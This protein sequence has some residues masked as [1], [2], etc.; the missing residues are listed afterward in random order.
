LLKVIPGI[1]RQ[2][3][4]KHIRSVDVLEILLLLPQ[5]S[6]QECGALTVSKALMLDR[7]SVETRLDAK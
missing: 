4:A 2:F 7:T 1:V 3:V 5:E 6:R